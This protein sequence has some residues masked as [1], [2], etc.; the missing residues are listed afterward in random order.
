MPPYLPLPKDDDLPSDIRETLSTLPPL[1][2]FRMTANAPASFKG[3]LELATSIL[4]RSEFDVRK[5]EIAVLRVA[6]VT[7]SNYVWTQHVRV[8]KT[9]G[10]TED[11]ITMIAKEDPVVSLDAE[12]NL[13]CRV[14]DEISRDIRL[15]DEALAQI[16]DS[17]GVRGAAEL[18][19]C[20]SYFNMLS[21][22]VESTRVE[23]EKKK[24]F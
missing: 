8:A 17:Y 16:L 23:L 24:A 7:R 3:F 20:L 13:L 9:A 2:V 15:S 12:G 1:N 14:A 11:E 6:H 5:R 21:R 22:F 4:L 10:V 18:I 19:L